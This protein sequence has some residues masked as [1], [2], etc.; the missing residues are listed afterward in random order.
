MLASTAAGGACGSF[1]TSARKPALGNPACRVAGA[2]A[3]DRIVL[4]LVID[5]HRLQ[6][7]TIQVS[8]VVRGL[9]EDGI[10][11]DDLVQLFTRERTRIVGELLDRPSAEVVDPFAWRDRLRAR[12][13]LL[14]R[15]GSRPDSIP[16]HFPLPRRSGAREMHVVVDESGN[17]RTPAQVDAPRGRRCEL[18]HLGISADSDDAIA[19]DGDGLGDREAL[20]DGDDLSVR[21]DDVWRGLLSGQYGDATCEREHQKHC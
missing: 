14:E 16:T 18:R 10:V 8:L 11:R 2:V 19:A 21:E 3:H 4:R 9:Q 20:V 7:A 1:A 17:D 6:C 15:G 12:A 5:A 13:Q